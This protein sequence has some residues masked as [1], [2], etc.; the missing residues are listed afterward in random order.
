[1]PQHGIG[2]PYWYEWEIGVI[3]C[4]KMLYDDS[5]EYVIFQDSKYQSIDDVV[6][7]KNGKTINIQV[8]HTDVDKNMTYSFL[9]KDDL[10]KSWA[11][12]WQNNGINDVSEIYI[13]S[14]MNYGTNETNGKVSFIRFIEEVLPE[15][16]KDYNFSSPEKEI[17]NAIQWY[18]GHISFL[19]TDASKFTSMLNFK[20]TA[21]LADVVTQINNMIKDLTHNE[22][23]TIVN[24]ISDKLHGKLLKWTTS[25]RLKPEVYPKD[26]YEALSHTEYRAEY[27]FKPQKPIF[28]SRVLFSNKLEALI[29]MNSNKVF[30]VSG[31]P[32]IGKTNFISY[33]AQ[34]ENSIVD[35]RFYT[36]K[37][38]DKCDNIYSDDYGKYKGSDL[39]LTILQ[40]LRHKFNEMGL[41]YEIKF[42]LLIDQIK[43]SDLKSVALNYLKTYYNKIGKCVVFIDGID[44]A[45]RFNDAWNKTYL[46]ELP[47]PSSIPDGVKFVIVGQPNYSNYPTWINEDEVA[48]IEMPGMDES[49]LLSIL[50]DSVNDNVDKKNLAKVIIDTVGNNTLNVLFAISEAKRLNVT[51]SFDDFILALKTKR[52]NENI[53]NYYNWIHE[54]LTKTPIMD[55][56]LFIFAFSNLKI[57]INELSELFKIGIFEMANHLSSVYPLIVNDEDDFY[58]VYHN[59]VRIYLKNK[60]CYRKDYKF[61]V[62]E[63]IPLINSNLKIKHDILIPCIQMTNGD[64]FKYFNIEYIKE[65]LENDLSFWNLSRDLDICFKNI[66]ETKR[67]EDVDDLSI[68]TTSIFQINNCYLWMNAGEDLPLPVNDVCNSEKY[69][70]NG[71]EDIKP[72]IFDTYNLLKRSCKKRA[73]ILYLEMIEQ[74]G[75]ESLKDYCFLE[76][77]SLLEKLGFILRCLDFRKAIEN[78]QTDEYSFLKGWMDASELDIENLSLNFAFMKE[79]YII[80]CVDIYLKHLITLDKNKEKFDFVINVIKN[81]KCSIEMLFNLYEYYSLVDLGKII[82]GEIVNRKSELIPQERDIYKKE[83]LLY[84]KYLYY[85]RDVIDLDSKEIYINFED[86]LK[87]YKIYNSRGYKPAIEIF[88]CFISLLKFTRG[89]CE[90]SD[91]LFITI[92]SKII[93]CSERYGIGSTYD[94][95][96]FSLSKFL[97]KVLYQICVNNSKFRDAV[98]DYLIEVSQNTSKNVVWELMPLLI[99]TG[100]K[101]EYINILDSWYNNEGKLWGRSIEDISS[102]GENI[103]EGLYSLGEID[104]S[105]NIQKKIRYKSRIGYVGQKDYS[106][107]DLADWYSILPSTSDKL[108]KYGVYLLAL[109]DFACEQGDNRGDKRVID[110]LIDAA[111]DLGAQYLDALFDLKNVSKEFYYWREKIVNRIKERGLLH[112]VE[113]LEREKLEELIILWGF[114]IENDTI[115][116]PFKEYEQKIITKIDNYGLDSAIEDIKLYLNDPTKYSKPTFLCRILKRIEKSNIQSFY[117][118]V[119]RDYIIQKDTYGF[120]HNWKD[121][122]IIEVNQYIS[123]EDYILLLNNCYVNFVNGNDWY[124]I[125]EDI[126]TL[127][128]AYMAKLGDEKI[129]E[130]YCKKVKMH[131][132]WIGIPDICSI[133]QYDFILDDRIKNYVDF[134]NKMTL[135]I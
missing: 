117:D 35:F 91:K 116:E 115:E 39:W 60:L 44:H 75:F 67:I 74:I 42:P 102:I 47:A 81:Y 119:I 13:Y 89:K 20:K 80:D 128:Y 123:D 40:Q 54:S 3:E 55:K 11:K 33:L 104:L 86:I 125:K 9:D 126:E 70:F 36:Y 28:N 38:V 112:E 32:G 69:V 94:F 12:D 66:I 127:C 107:Y 10:L 72:F 73:E 129:L 114:E 110:N 124:N 100:R 63:M 111:L 49:D 97:Y 92:T 130:C 53:N 2:T 8:K 109:S 64:L 82:K 106:F 26:V 101:N 45:A 19:G 41:L 50:E 25:L 22:D 29:N 16:K 133:S 59:D 121:K 27:D 23:D 131:E 18:R 24:D 113:P 98:C 108:R 88:N 30:F 103:I 68:M 79:M 87:F 43:Q 7:K 17:E 90:L 58:Y 21:S 99:E 6:V 95:N 46:P 71:I 51:N 48:K 34:K 135:K 134:F 105:N 4:L 31:P 83:I 96:Y 52:L 65:Y 78:I 93:F 118:K 5:I 61:L 76:D 84:F 122:L 77:R 120:S 132:V 62:Q 37:P 56:I 15:L 14:N 85:C 1:M 57:H